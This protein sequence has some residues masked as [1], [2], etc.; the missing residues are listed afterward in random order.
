MLGF[1]KGKSDLPAN[2]GAGDIVKFFRDNPEAITPE[3]QKAIAQFAIVQDAAA[4]AIAE[5]DA[6]E[7]KKNYGEW[8]ALFLA[9]RKSPATRRAYAR[10]IGLFESFCAAEGIE[11]T[12][13]KYA[14]AVKY[15]QAAE[16]TQKQEGGQRAPESIRRD[17]AALSAFYTEL[18]KMS[19]SK[20]AN[21]FIRIGTKPARAKTHIK[22][23]PSLADFEAILG[24]AE[25]TERAA[26][27]I[28]A[29]RGL[30]IGA[31]KG[32][33]LQTKDG[34]TTFET[35]TKGKRQSGTIGADI[36]A[37]LAKAGLPKIEPFAGI[38]TAALAMRIQRALDKMAASGVI[39]GAEKERKINGKETERTCSRFSCHSFRHF[40][41]VSEYGKD[42]DIER[43]R[44]LL[45]HSNVNTTQIYLQSLGLIG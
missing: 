32:L 39:G 3:L 41:A 9:T 7:L 36:A 18:Y 43:L 12:A 4:K 11:P 34:K 5:A 27:Y 35:I 16:L 40:Y 1:M 15:T 45:N 42:R 10:A 37:E 31:L 21:P 28:M 2:I 14:Q 25:G 38:G 20:I 13:L 24:H 22:D 29:K 44:K 33:H 26:I 30:R 6:A 23:V 17:I 8:K 19:E